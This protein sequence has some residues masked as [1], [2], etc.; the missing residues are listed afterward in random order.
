MSTAGNTR[1]RGESDDPGVG[2]GVIITGGGQTFSPAGRYIIVST[3]GTVT[4]QLVGDT[5]DIAYVPPTGVHTLAIESITSVT[6]LVGCIV[7]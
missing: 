6:S 5:G 3:A 4:G 1:I 2:P 7:R